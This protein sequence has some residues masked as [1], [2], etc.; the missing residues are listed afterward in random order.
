MDFALEEDQALLV[1]TVRRFAERSL[2]SA[3][4][5]ADRAAAPPPQL[6]ATA[7]D[8]GFLL[9][10]VPAEAGGLLEGPYPHLLRALRGLEL[11]RG[12]AGL[13]ALLETNVEPALAVGRWG[14]DEARAAL[15]GALTRAPDQVPGTFPGLATTARDWRG[16]VGV[17]ASAGGELVLTGSLG[18]LPAMAAAGHVLFV[19]RIGEAGSGGGE[20]VL[21]LIPTASDGATVAA[22]APSG[23]RAARWGTLALERVRLPA[24]M[25]I[26]R[27]A[28]AAAAIEQVLAWYRSS[29]AARAVGVAIAAMEHARRYGEERIQFDQP[30][31]RFESLIRMRDENETA[32]AA[33]RGL[34]LLA[35]WQLDRG[36]SEAPDSAS[37][38]RAFAG[39]VVAR[40]TIDA[41]QM[42]GGYGFV[43]DY[44]VEKLM[45]D[46]RAFEV[47]L[48]NEG[49][50]RVLRV[51][52]S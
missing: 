26:A 40:A 22:V 45:R 12:C 44:P 2:R 18:P 6:A 7:A 30:I 28:A 39:G 33:A 50:D 19:G 11:G 16:A 36:L 27:G 31:G 20:P 10:A 41:V 15:F 29:L 21:A 51:R 37:R 24:A 52:G 47:L 17:A 13:A 43:N 14:S 35:A 38:A 3:A 42:L 32:A 1:A 48:G 46:A 8:V 4:A 25:V 9:D 23:W 5:D 34:V 49:L